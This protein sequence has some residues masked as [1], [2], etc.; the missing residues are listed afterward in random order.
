MSYTKRLTVFVFLCFVSLYTKAQTDTAFWFAAPAITSGHADRPIVL[1]ISS[2]DLS[3]TVTIT[4]PANPSFPT[5]NY[6]LNPYSAQ[7]VD[8]TYL[9]TQIESEPHNTVLNYGIKISASA[10]IS[11]YY[12]VEGKVGSGYNNPEIFPLKGKI[13]KGLN[14]MIPGQK[15]FDNRVFSGPGNLI[16][17]APNS[18]FVVVATEDNTSIDITPSN[19]AVGHPATQKFSI[20]LNKG[21]SYSVIANS[22]IGPAHLVGSIVTANKPI[23]VTIYDDSIG[24]PNL[25]YDLCGDQIVPEEANGEEFVIVK[26]E[27]NVSNQGSDYYNILATANNTDI[28]LNGANSPIATLQRGQ[29]YANLLNQTSLYIK[30]SNPVYVNQLTGTGNEMTF[31]DLPSIHCTGSSMVS[32]VRSNI[33]NFYLNL[34]CKKESIDSFFLNG[35]S[36]IIKGYMFSAV[37]GTNGDWMFARISQSNLSNI[38]SLIPA[39]GSTVRISNTLGLFHLGFLNGDLT[40]GAVLGYFSNY[41]QTT[42]APIAGGI[43]CAGNNISLS[44]TLVAGTTYQ[45]NGPNNFNATTNN[46]IIYHASPSSSGYYKVLANIMGCGT[47]TDSILVTVHPLPTVTMSAGDSICLGDS[48]TFKMDFTGAAPW[49]FS[50]TDGTKIDTVQQINNTP[51]SLVVKPSVNTTYS[52]NHITDSNTCT[53]TATTSTVNIV[54]LVKINPLPTAGFNFSSVQC[55]NRTVLF[56]DNSSANAGILTRWYWDFGDGTIK[57][58]TSGATFG[59]VFTKWGNYSIRLMVETNNGCKSDTTISNKQINALPH[60]GFILPEV[61]VTDGT[62]TFTDTST[63]ADASQSQFIWSWKIFPGT[64]NNKQPVFVDAFAQNAKV[65]V[66]KEDYYNTMLKV[67]SKD[68]CVDSLFQRLTVNG[69]TPK[70][71]FVIQNANGLCSNDSIRIMNTSNV[72]FGSVT[73]LDI[74]W[75]AINAPAVKFPDENPID[76]NLYATQYPNFPSPAIKTYTVKLIAFSGNAASCQNTATQVVTINRSPQITFPKPRDIC[77]DASPRIIVPQATWFTG[78]P[79]AS[80]T[81]SG[82]G[83]TNNITGLFDPSITGAGTFNI[84]FLQVSDKGCK[85][86][87]TQPITVWPSPVAKWG[88]SATL[89]EKNQILFTDSSVANFSAI[90]QRIWVFDDGSSATKNNA[91]TFSHVYTSSKIYQASLKVITDSGC[92]STIN[93]QPLNVQYLPK[94]DFSLPSVCLPDGR[95]QFNS[96]SSIADGTDALFSYRWNFNDPADPTSSTLTNPIH[97]FSALGPYP[98][99]LIV[100]SNNNCVDSATKILST[101]YPQPKADFSA[102]SLDVCTK[103]SIQF[104]DLSDGKT[105]AINSWTWDLANGDASILQNPSKNFV[106]TGS[107]QIKLFITNLQ[108][109]VSDTAIKQVVVHPYPVLMMGK[110]KLVLEGG[111]V[112]LSAQY[113]YGTQLSYLWTPSQ[114]LSSDTAQAPLSSPIDDI[115]YH[116]LLT[117]IGGCSVSD[118]LFVKV[119]KSPMIPNAFSPNGDGI[120]DTWIIQYLESYPGT[121]VDVFNRYGQKVF[122]SIGYTTPWDGRYNGKILPVGTYYYV[123]NPKNGRAIMSGS[124]TIIL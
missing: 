76:S 70:A 64:N 97:K 85:D 4:E 17:P 117:G 57:D 77:L 124:V 46:A 23:C 90:K 50:Y 91:D 102:T 63:I 13:S 9:I 111:T 12:E 121:T 16:T 25:S 93:L 62:A 28:F 100:R 67:T 123:I 35:V 72:A 44:S 43:K 5:L 6:N 29:V 18:G 83:I 59:K 1:R 19:Q 89:C 54:R 56:T 66:T 45:W 37:P 84:Q 92:V 32:F 116:L 99:Q 86:S 55:E 60:V 113:I 80:N 120:N 11:A 39:D 107:F 96:S 109:C 61:C 78:F 14:F 51:Y 47:F 79:V 118:T 53:A 31:T 10:N 95:G 73:R 98:V 74:V 40:T 26:G 88:V 21:Q 48:K 38:N 119:L 110:S 36:G 7:T 101:I 82:K 30:T 24:P 103:T 68:G 112:A 104:N 27:L 33:Y 49:T 58:T 122:S 41:A 94:V 108:G 65:L 42:L 22:P 105:S 71:S 8:L 69:P 75:D 114:F 34:L 87:A 20:T 106:D 52:L 3:S 15:Q 2:Y 81:Y 115:T